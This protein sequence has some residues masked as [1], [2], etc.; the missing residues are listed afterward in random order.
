MYTCL[1]LPSALPSAPTNQTAN[2]GADSIGKHGET[3][4]GDASAVDNKTVP[5]SVVTDTSISSSSGTVPVVEHGPKERE[6]IGPSTPRPP[7]PVIEFVEEEVAQSGKAIML[8]GSGFGMDN[9]AVRIM[10]G[11]RECRDPELCHRNCRPCDDEHPCDF[12]EMCADEEMSKDNKKVR[13]VRSIILY[14]GG[15]M[16]AGLHS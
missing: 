12:D 11:G 2:G 8:V 16:P 5:D 14:Q 9:E 6:G 3:E 4:G 7:P 15:V 10:I 1:N 13:P